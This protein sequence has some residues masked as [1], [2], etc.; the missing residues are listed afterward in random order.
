MHC[1]DDAVI[2]S[3]HKEI[4]L[5]VCHNWYLYHQINLNIRYKKWYLFCYIIDS[6]FKYNYLISIKQRLHLQ[7]LN[8]LL[9]TYHGMDLDPVVFLI[10]K[11]KAPVPVNNSVFLLQKNQHKQQYKSNFSEMNRTQLFRIT[12]NRRPCWSV[13]APS[14]PVW[15]LPLRRRSLDLK[16]GYSHFHIIKKSNS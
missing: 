10:Y 9:I 8:F 13:E 14:S 11:T 15:F 7:K 5:I 4:H 1:L 2:R 12:C 3:K 16:L 6:F